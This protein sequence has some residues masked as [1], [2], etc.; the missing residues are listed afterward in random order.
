MMLTLAGFA[1]VAES[2]DGA[3]AVRHVAALDPDV[4]VLDKH[5]PR[6]TGEKAAERIREISSSVQILALSANLDE[7]PEWA[8][9]WL[10][11]FSIG[12]LPETIDA[13]RDPL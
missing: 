1:V 4:V 3:E 13:L 7:K 11:K 5:M 10:P 8:D 12:R 6:L 2:R 9:A